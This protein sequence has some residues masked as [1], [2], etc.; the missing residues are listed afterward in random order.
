MRT[1][2]IGGAVI[3]FGLALG[4]ALGY[5]TSAIVSMSAEPFIASPYSSRDN[6]TN[7]F[8]GVGRLGASDD[9][10]GFCNGPKPNPSAQDYLRNEDYAI[11][12]IEDHAPA[13]G[14]N[15]PLDIARARLAVRRAMLAE[16]NGDV[17]LKMKYENAA[18]ELL[19][20]SG[21][22]DPSAAH[23]RQIVTQI[24]SVGSTC[25]PSAAPERQAK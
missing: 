4:Y 24:D 16:K 8:R 2:I 7:V 19:Q 18:A 12:A 14:L 1:R 5:G 25:S 9:A 21:W 13:S 15:P 11:R 22:R 6:F 17:Q 3:L 20:K 10:A 23:M